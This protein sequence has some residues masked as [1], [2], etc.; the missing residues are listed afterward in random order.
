LENSC[1]LGRGANPV[2][3]RGRSDAGGAPTVILQRAGKGPRGMFG[4]MFDDG[5]KIFFTTV[6]NPDKLIPAGTY[7]VGR[8]ASPKRGGKI[9]F[10]LVRV[11]KRSD[12][13]L[14]SGADRDDTVGCI[15]VGQGFGE[16][17]NGAIVTNSRAAIRRL[18]RFMANHKTFTLVV[19]NPAT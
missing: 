6:E 15:V 2:G 14:H 17:D 11:P 7:T 18:E 12:I 10:E 13:Q 5:A 19:R 16:G 1:R 8:D 3:V 9:V 4:V